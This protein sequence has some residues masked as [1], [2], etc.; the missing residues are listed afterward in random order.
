MPDQPSP[1]WMQRRLQMVGQRPINNIVDVTNYITFEIGQPL[2]AFDYDKLV[3]RAGG[4][5]ADHHHAPAG[6]AKRWRRWTNS[7]QADRHNILVCDT[8][9]S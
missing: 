5:A 9:A 4:K 2:H 1:E 8:L 7:P 6:Q 3:A